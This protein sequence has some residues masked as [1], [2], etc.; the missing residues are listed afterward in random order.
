M[1]KIRIVI[2]CLLI[3]LNINAQEII[4]PDSNIR[5]I[6]CIKKTSDNQ[7]FGQVNFRILY[8]KKSKYVEV[9]ANSPLGISR[10][11]Q[12][13]VDNLRFIGESKATK[14]H[15]KYQMI[16]GKR[17]LCENFGTEKIFS[18]K[19]SNNQPLDII[20]RVYN[21]GVAFRFRFPNHSDSSVNI[22]DEAT[23]YVLPDS[24]YRWMQPYTEAYEDFF[25]FS[26]T[27]EGGKKEKE[28]GIPSLFKV[29]N[30]N[31]WMLISEANITENNC[32]AKLCNLV[33]ANEYKVTYPS[34]RK[35][36]QQ[37]GVVSTLPWSSQWHTFIIGKLADIVESTLV[38]DVSEPN[39]LKST[40]WIKP[41]PV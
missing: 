11:D 14:I 22:T 17:K 35:D 20:F 30:E 32:A 19:N 2:C 38:T 8:K 26:K 12:Q 41:G 28:W 4:S 13:F 3:S 23:A 15:D 34:A 40:D 31:V 9:L 10:A 33:N 36:F 29:N 39:K 18:Y 21:D 25:P 1:T 37:T 6:L 7:S 27:G 24:T 16:C 5:V